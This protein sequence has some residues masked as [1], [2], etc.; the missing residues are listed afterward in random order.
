M[1]GFPNESQHIIGQLLR[2]TKRAQPSLAEFVNGRTAPGTRELP[3]LARPVQIAFVE[4]VAEALLETGL[5]RAADEGVDVG[6]AQIAV[7]AQEP[8]YRHV[9]GGQFD[10]LSCPRPTHP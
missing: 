6:R 9:A 8:E 7:L 4:E 10:P 5:G 3:L 1:S 2:L